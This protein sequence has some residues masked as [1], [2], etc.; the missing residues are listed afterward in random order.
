MLKFSTV[1]FVS[2]FFF[3]SNSFAKMY[4]WTDENGKT[5][6]SNTV[7]PA[8]AKKVEEQPEYK[9]SLDEQVRREEARSQYREEAAKRDQ[10]RKSLAEHNRLQKRNT[11]V[12]HQRPKHHPKQ[13]SLQDKAKKETQYLEKDMD[14]ALDNCRKSSSGYKK[15]KACVERVKTKY[16]IK[17]SKVENDPE[18]YFA[19][20]EKKSSSKNYTKTEDRSVKN[21]PNKNYWDG[22]DDAQEGSGEWSDDPNYL[23]G[24]EDAQ[25]ENRRR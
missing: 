16:Q 22:Y 2:I 21:D 10:A 25:M 15:R 7:P 4:E 12:N 20:K 17:I 11:P 1:I 13:E 9:M 6:Y 14:Y 24:Y 23:D 5:H 8:K 3:S 18:Y 19:R